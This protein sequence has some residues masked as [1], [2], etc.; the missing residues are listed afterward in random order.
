MKLLSNLPPDCSDSD[1]L[2]NRPEDHA[3]DKAIEAKQ[4]EACKH[5]DNA[6][7]AKTCHQCCMFGDD[8]GFEKEEDE[9]LIGERLQAEAANRKDGCK[10][11]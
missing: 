1:I 7:Y 6:T 5:L 2:G 8:A 4:C 3:I 9:A 11:E 10:D